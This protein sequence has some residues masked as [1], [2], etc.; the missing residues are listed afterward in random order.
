MVWPWYINIALKK[1]LG[2]EDQGNLLFAQSAKRCLL[3][4][5]ASVFAIFFCGSELAMITYLS[6][7]RKKWGFGSIYSANIKL[8][9]VFCSL[10]FVNFVSVFLVQCSAFS[11][12]ASKQC[13]EPQRKNF[14][15]DSSRLYCIDQVL[16]NFDNSHL[17]IQ[18][19]FF[20]I[21]FSKMFWL[22]N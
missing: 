16:F 14:K 19:S 18:L 10:C 4:Y 13:T 5:D 11:P 12:L 1:G 15:D 22:C 3:I 6:R 8:V 9:W 17:D 21:Y 7:K 20:I 2:F